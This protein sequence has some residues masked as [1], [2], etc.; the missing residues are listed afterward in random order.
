VTDAVRTTGGG[1]ARRMRTVLVRMRFDPPQAVGG[2][3]PN[4]DWIDFVWAYDA[5][6]VVP[7]APSL[8]IISFALIARSG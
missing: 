5:V 1:S 6:G 8:R 3:V 7:V 2:E 4:D